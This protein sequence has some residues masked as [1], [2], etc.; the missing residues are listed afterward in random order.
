MEWVSPLLGRIL[1]TGI[2]AG[3]QLA[4]GRASKR[5]ADFEAAQLTQRAGEARA[6]SHRQAEEAR[7]ES[8]LLQSR[9]LAVAAASGAG[10]SDPS[11]VNAIAN[12]AKR[13][14][15][16]IR[17]RVYEGEAA[18]R[19]YE[20]AAT[21]RR[22]EGRQMEKAG[23]MR[24]LSTVVQGGLS[25]YGRYGEEDDPANASSQSSTAR[26]LEYDDWWTE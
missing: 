22:Y 23:E 2:T 25:L 24:A 1:G 20:D 16:S 18:G 11:V 9:A 19:R 10:A 12:I 15:Y 3:S 5:A 21:A 14:D 7:L 8:V 6:V 26:D 17:S 13:G 4:A